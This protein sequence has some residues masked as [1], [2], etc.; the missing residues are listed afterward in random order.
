MVVAKKL[1][2]CST[3]QRVSISTRAINGNIWETLAVTLIGT[4]LQN[5]CCSLKPTMHNVPVSGRQLPKQY[6]RYIAYSH[7][8]GYVKR[9]V[10]KGVLKAQLCFCYSITT[11]RARE[12]FFVQ[13]V[14]YSDIYLY[15][16]KKVVGTTRK[17]KLCCLNC[18]AELEW[19]KTFILQP[20]EGRNRQ[21][22]VPAHATFSTNQTSRRK[23]C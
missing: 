21:S 4:C 3:F 17:V 2:F 10:E 18:S 16:Q 14:C 9:P 19:T 11:S 6:W 20:L 13:G 7:F 23:Q 12:L 5:T 15:K 22:D 8:I 1:Y